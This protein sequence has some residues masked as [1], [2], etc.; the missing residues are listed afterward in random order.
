MSG[1][2][3]DTNFFIEAH[4][5]SYPLDVA[6]SFWNKIRDL[7]HAGKISSIDKVKAEIYSNEDPLKHWCNAN[8]PTNFFQDSSGCLPNYITL[9]TWANSRIPPFT[10]AA[11]AEFLGADEADAWLVAQALSSST[12]I[13]IVTQEVSA[14][15]MIRRVKLPDVCVAHNVDYCNAV[16]MFRKLGESF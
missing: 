5:T 2:L 13:T 14:P 8:I 6:P 1:F 9:T 12:K 7:S 11:L 3:L 10:P 16:E 4:R 15:L